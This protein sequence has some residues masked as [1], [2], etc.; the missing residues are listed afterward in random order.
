MTPKDVKSALGQRVR[1]PEGEYLFTAYI[2]RRDG[3]K[4][5]HQAELQ[6]LTALRSIRICRLE[7]IEI[8]GE[9]KT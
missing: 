9:E 4:I 8:V 2:L 6:D 5:L 7:E 3:G 1:L